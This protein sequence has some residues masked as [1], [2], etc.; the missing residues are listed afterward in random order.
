VFDKPT[1]T[2]FLKIISGVLPR[3]VLLKAT[4]NV[5]AT[6]EYEDF[7][8]YLADWRMARQRIGIEEDPPMLTI[9][10]EPKTPDK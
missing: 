4:L 10:A 5:T 6:S 8:Q 7:A 1:P 2:A 3:E 9:N